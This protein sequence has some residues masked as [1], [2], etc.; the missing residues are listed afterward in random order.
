MHICCGLQA[1]Y[2]ILHSCVN[3]FCYL[4]TL[5]SLYCLRCSQLCRGHAVGLGWQ[6]WRHLFAQAGTRN[7]GLLWSSWKWNRD[8]S[9]RVDQDH[10]LPNCMTF[11]FVI[12]INNNDKTTHGDC[13]WKS[14]LQY[15]LSSV[16]TSREQG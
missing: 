1:S 2:I 5:S 12:Y 10:V 14:V 16:V 11:V 8:L 6:V 13:G 7:S 9:I 15:S 4:L 3:F